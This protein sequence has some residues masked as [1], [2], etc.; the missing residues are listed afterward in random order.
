MQALDPPEKNILQRI[1]QKRIEVPTMA[2]LDP[3]NRLFNYK[4]GL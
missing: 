3:K 1:S 2:E 4:D